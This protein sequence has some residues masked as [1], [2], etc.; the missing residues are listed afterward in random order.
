MCHDLLLLL[1]L[2]V[3]HVVVIFFVLL[4]ILHVIVLIV[5]LVGIGINIGDTVIASPRRTSTSSCRPTRHLCDLHQAR[6]VEQLAH[7]RQR[8]SR[9]GG[10][11]QH[12]RPLPLI[13]EPSLPAP[14][15]HQEP[16]QIAC[17]Q[18]TYRALRA[19]RPSAP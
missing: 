12:R 16:V 7:P 2:Y 19:P 6:G 4:G 11:P 14:A 3:F 1:Y 17:Q 10:R 15:S 13:H 9:R 5:V 8:V 18:R